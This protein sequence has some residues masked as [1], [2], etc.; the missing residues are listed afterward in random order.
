MKYDAALRE[1]GAQ[2]LESRAYQKNNKIVRTSV[3]VE[4]EFKKGYA[5]CNG[6]DPDC[7]CSFAESPSADVIVV[8]L[9]VKGRKQTYSMSHSNF[10]FSEILRE[11]VAAEKRMINSYE[12]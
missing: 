1:W 6:S 2:K 11:I 5:C 10:N 9:D 12:S 8:G 7:Y 3:K 4:M